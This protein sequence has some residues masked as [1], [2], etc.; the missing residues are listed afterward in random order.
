MTLLKERIGRREEGEGK[1][2]EK[3]RQTRGEGREDNKGKEQEGTG[4]KEGM[5]Q[6]YNLGT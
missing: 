2:E 6:L 1:G 5:V 3:G 4:G